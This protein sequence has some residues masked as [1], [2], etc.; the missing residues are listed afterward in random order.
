M[1]LNG[2]DFLTSAPQ[3]FIFQRK[4]NKTNFGGVLS[5]IYLLIF[6]TITSF[7][8]V[9][10]YNEDDYSIQYLYQEKV[11]TNKEQREMIN[12]TRYNPYFNFSFNLSVFEDKE[13]E[14]RLKIIDNY[15]I[16][17]H[18]INKSKSRK[19]KLQEIDWYIAIDCLT[20]NKTQC[21]IDIEKY[22]HRNIILRLYYN[23]FT[24]DH[25]NKTSPLYRKN[26]EGI[27]HSLTL[28]YE[29][30]NPTRRYE[31]FNLIR[32]KEQKGFFSMFEN[33]EDNDYIGLGRKSYDYS[34]MTSIDGSKN[35]FTYSYDENFDYHINQVIGRVVF[36]IDFNHY[37]EYK[38]TPKSIWDTLANIC[39]LSMTLLNGLSFTFVNYF[40][41]NFD[42]YKIMEKI[43]Y[44]NNNFKPIK[45]DKKNKE[46]NELNGDLNKNKD[47]L[48]KSNED[49]D[50]LII[51][52]DNNNE[53][54]QDILNENFNNDNENFPKL[55]CF[56]FLFSGIYNGKCCCK[57]NVKKL[58]EKSNEII[59]KYYSIENIIYNQIK[60]E[61]M[62]KDYRWN[63]QELNNFDNN[64]LVI[65][66]KNLISPFNND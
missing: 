21:Q 7:Y 16:F 13:L 47:L 27:S 30:F 65:Q 41:N 23:G 42:N 46:I 19:L 49:K 55:N 58:I 11:L 12:S 45:K 17:N 15:H 36:A 28:I 37:D 43:I 62:L 52:D 51:N 50:I 26:G 53:E 61:N 18:E 25:Q 29:L 63:N 5:F 33:E 39:S 64:D 6:L 54:E 8:L 24:L 38:R 48:N 57:L 3:N 20:K 60:F 35:I 1:R 9:S 59:S 66:F 4:S 31:R 32:Y 14:D 2:F 40:S 44:N 56:D 10:Y 34:E 22:K